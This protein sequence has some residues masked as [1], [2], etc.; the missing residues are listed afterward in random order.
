LHQFA[1]RDEKQC[2]GVPKC[3]RL[4]QRRMNTPEQVMQPLKSPLQACT[5]MPTNIRI[6]F[7]QHT[8]AFIKEF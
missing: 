6:G 4:N 7:E 8:F 1:K 5:K 2:K 3:S